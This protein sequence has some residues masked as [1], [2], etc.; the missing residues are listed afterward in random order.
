MEAEKK[1]KKEGTKTVL[2]KFSEMTKEEISALPRCRFTMRQSRSNYSPE[3][4]YSAI[5]D[6]GHSLRAAVSKDQFGE[7]TY[8]VIATIYSK[9]GEA[10]RGEVDLV[11][12][13][14]IMKGTTILEDGRRFSY[15]QFDVLAFRD[16]E[17]GEI[18]HFSGFFDRNQ[19]L[20][21]RIKHLDQALKAVDRGVTDKS[22]IPDD[23]F[24]DSFLNSVGNN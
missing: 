9:E 8:N 15:Y 5:L 14:V 13:C 3:P 1:Q 18:I 17:T 16:V 24:S 23:V 7:S 2:K 10:L 21:I 11:M 19:R 12:P 4:R 6:F 20:Y 22:A